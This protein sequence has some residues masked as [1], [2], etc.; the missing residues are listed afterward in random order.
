MLSLLS[1]NITKPYLKWYL[2]LH[3]YCVIPHSVIKTLVSLLWDFYPQ[4]LTLQKKPKPR[5]QE[6]T[7][8]ALNHKYSW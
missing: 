5:P 6:C 1:K 8:P 4:H 2:A 7:A 3:K